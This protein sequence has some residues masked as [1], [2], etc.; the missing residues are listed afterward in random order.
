MPP[1]ARG[2]GCAC[3]AARLHRRRP[4]RPRLRRGGLS[5]RRADGGRPADCAGGK[6]PGFMVQALRDPDGANLDR[7]QIIK[8]WLDV[9]RRDAR[10]DLRRCRVRRAPDRRRTAGR[11]RRWGRP[12]TC[13]GRPT[14]TRSAR[15][16]FKA[17]WSDPD[18]DAAEDAFYY[19]RVLEI[20]TPRWTTHDA[21]VLRRA[22]ARHGAADGAGH[23]PIP[24]RSGTR[25]ADTIVPEDG[26][27]PAGAA[28]GCRPSS[29]GSGIPSTRGR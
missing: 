20:P 25:R 13:R 27:I 11:A 1:P 23:G 9:H 4:G 6:A 16:S 26:L 21:G 2:S 29:A 3:S 8:G 22:P 5:P 15:R 7:V 19:V 24:R 14:P 10:A 17:F 28:P 12:S 18:F